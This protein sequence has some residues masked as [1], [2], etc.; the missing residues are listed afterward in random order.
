MR[1]RYSYHL[2]S[3]PAAAFSATTAELRGFT[4]IQYKHL[5]AQVS[6][7]PPSRPTRKPPP[8]MNKYLRDK[9][10]Q[11]TGRISVR[12]RRWNANCVRQ[13]LYQVGTWNVRDPTSRVN[14]RRYRHSRAC[15]L[16]N[17]RLCGKTI[18]GAPAQVGMDDIWVNDGFKLL[19]NVGHGTNASAG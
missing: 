11:N 6:P 9:Q 13:T 7:F 12:T 10:T 16:F 8:D 5:R 17:V 2:F 3:P 15:V 1:C 4:A 14:T 19:L 18:I